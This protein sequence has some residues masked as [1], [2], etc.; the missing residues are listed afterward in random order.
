M[1][2]TISLLPLLASIF[3]GVL[4]GVELRQRRLVLRPFVTREDKP[5]WYWAEIFVGSILAAI[6]LSQSI[7][8]AM[9]SG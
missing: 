6:L 3:I 4:V 2:V 1:T 8:F 9:Q 5:L 7:G